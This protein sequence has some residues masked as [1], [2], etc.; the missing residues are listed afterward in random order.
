VTGEQIKTRDA[1]GEE[2]VTS[3]R[4]KTVAKPAGQFENAKA[5]EVDDEQAMRLIDGGSAIPAD[6]KA[7]KDLAKVRERL[8]REARDDWPED[9]AERQ[10]EDELDTEGQQGDTGFLKPP[11]IPARGHEGEPRL[12][13]P[14]RK[15]GPAVETVGPARK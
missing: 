8:A 5:I 10:V 14:G 3:V 12:S 7:I 13:E 15:G 4:H 11:S 1:K 6:A 2:K 9:D